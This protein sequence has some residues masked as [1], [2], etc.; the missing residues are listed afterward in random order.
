[1]T[2]SF[3]NYR[4]A[5]VY[6]QSRTALIALLLLFYWSEGAQKMRTAPFAAVTPD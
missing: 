2:N 3:A 4:V 1:M 5:K 6:V